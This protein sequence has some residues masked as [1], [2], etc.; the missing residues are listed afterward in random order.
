[1]SNKVGAMSM[2]Q[3]TQRELKP[4][5][6]FPEFWEA[7]EWGSA[8]G[9]AIF[10]QISNKDHNSDLPVLAITQEHGAIPRNLINYHV[11]VAEKSI[12]VYKVVE[13]GEFIISLRSFQGGIEYS[14]YKGICS[15]A[16][17][18]LR[19]KP[20]NLAHFF[21]HFLKTVRFIGQLNKNIEGLRDGK[22]VSYK[23]FSE[24][25]LPTPS[26][27]E[28][29]KITDCLSSLDELIT[30]QTQ[31]LDKL[32]IHKKGLMQQL[33]PAEGEN[34]PR[35]RFTEFWEAG[36]WDKDDL[37]KVAFFVNE[38]IA[39][40]HLPL[41]NYVSTENILPDYEGLITA[42]KLPS[43]GHATRFKI[44]DILIS[45]I[46]PYLKKVWYASKEG[47]ASND[48]IVVRA[49]EGIISQ[50]LS[51]MLKN[52]AFIEYV[53]K[54]AKG[55][56]MPRGDISLIKEYPFAYPSK[57]EQ[58][59]IADCLSSLDELITAQTQKLDK[60]KAHK[61]GLMQQLF[62]AQDEVSA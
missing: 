9:N 44:N 38:R 8:F 43:S 12:E 13:A 24:L 29:Q 5:L 33:F 50:Y 45:N 31:K 1:M 56:K 35:L 16:Y 15:P 51:F 30:A 62:P 36:E 57:T 53:M 7:G 6:R 41:A 48:V 32:K 28:Q 23:Q 60:L 20:G 59:R 47:G 11:S 14:E 42:S 18:I 61:K 54:G 37:G 21:R 4:K 2:K 52:N 3:E 27:Q 49:K 19:L 39:L 58:I 10:D 25:R 22:M 34:L 46:R 17:V 26:L 55:V 40:D